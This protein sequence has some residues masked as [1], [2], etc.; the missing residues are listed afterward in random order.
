MIPGG[1]LYLQ[2]PH[3]A[4]AL[5]ILEMFVA[6]V[7]AGSYFAYGTMG[8]AGRWRRDGEVA[9]RLGLVPLPLMLVVA[10]ILIVDLG[11]PLRF[12]NLLLTASDAVPERGGPLMFNLASP[13]SVGTYVILIF[14]LFT[15]V[16]FV[17]GLMHLSRLGRQTRFEG[18]AHNKIWQGVGGFLALMT[19]S[20]SGV[21]LNV[22]QQTVWTDTIF[23][24]GLYTAMAALCGLGV[25]AI[26]ADR[27]GADATAAAIREGLLWVAIVN[28]VLVV[29][30]VVTLGSYARVVALSL[31]VAPVFWVGLVILG[32]ALPIYLVRA[33]FSR[34][35]LAL[36]GWLTLVGALSSRYV[37]LFS[38]VAAL[39]S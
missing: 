11:Q 4:G 2:E 12:P 26:I 23:H 25:A 22:T 28:V 3:W 14:G 7:A 32:L 38:A 19:G 20:Y 9:H 10:I 36:A 35:N 6:A 39:Q 29:L 16:A 1:R 18:L 34:R 33:R 37:I 8:I 5:L 30:F 15:L 24:G 13:M 31:V 21:L 17:D 27:R